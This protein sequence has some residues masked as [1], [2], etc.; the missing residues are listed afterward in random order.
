MKANSQTQISNIIYHF[1]KFYFSQINDQGAWK[2]EN[3]QFLF[4]PKVPRGGGGSFEF[5]NIL[6]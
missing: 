2:S 4:I 6:K 5:G 3:S 1:Q